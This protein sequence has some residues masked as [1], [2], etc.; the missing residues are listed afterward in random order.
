MLSLSYDET[1]QDQ[2]SKEEE[3]EEKPVI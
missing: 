1:A 3:E 2:S